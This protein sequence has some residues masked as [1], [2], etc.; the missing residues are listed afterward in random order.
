MYEILTR[1]HPGKPFEFRGFASVR[2]N[3]TF[4]EMVRRIALNLAVA[5]G[6]LK[7]QPAKGV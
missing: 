5:V 3:E 2:P 1:N 6:F 4:S 7:L